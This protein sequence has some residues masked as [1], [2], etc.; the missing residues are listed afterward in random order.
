MRITKQA[1]NS[2][3]NKLSKIDRT[4]A[5]VMQRWIDSNSGASS[6]NIVSAAYLLT[7]K[8]GEA[9]A[10]LA[11]EMYDELAIAQGKVIQPAVPVEP[12]GENYVKSAV[13]GTIQEKGINS[14]PDLVSRMVKQTGADTTLKN[15]KRDGAYFAWI[16]G[17][18]SCAFCL[19]L[20]SR[21]WQKASKKTIKG[22][23]AEH[24]HNH[25]KC[26]FAINFDGPGVVEGYDPDKYKRMYDDAEGATP[27][28]RINYMRRQQYT[29][30]KDYI[31]AQ[32]RTAYIKRVNN[33]QIRIAMPIETRQPVGNPP[34]IALFGDRL[35][36][37]QE[38]LLKKL[39]KYDEKI[40]VNK[41]EVSMKDL[42]ALSAHENVEFAV[43]TKKGKRLIIR[44]GRND[45]NIDEKKMAELAR[46]GYKWSGHTHPVTNS[47]ELV[48][49]EGDRCVLRAS[50]RQYSVI[51]SS[52]GKKYVFG[53]EEKDDI[54]FKD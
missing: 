23:H 33:E 51:Y 47:L 46:Q 40:E 21:G 3:V 6:E 24:I 38:K 36:K 17:G 26:E 34:G 7:G 1:W 15:A 52:T 12:P 41:R 22:D 20:A 11:C 35:S 29:V 37:R 30:N 32:K 10:A 48:P 13:S 45:V 14:V 54:G 39:Q 5:V 31:N 53:I 25:C 19:T 9:A 18:D 44:G 50:G 8:Y 27:Q 42:A 2:Y 4:A 16:P 43:F 49:S 28:D